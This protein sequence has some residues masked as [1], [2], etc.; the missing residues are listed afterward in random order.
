MCRIKF[1]Y[2]YNGMILAIFN[3]TGNTPCCIDLLIKRVN[4]LIKLSIHCFIIEAG[5]SSYPDDELFI[6]EIVDL[7][8]TLSSSGI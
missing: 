6:E 5:N 7:I 4:G 2:K 3:S 1:Y 8:S